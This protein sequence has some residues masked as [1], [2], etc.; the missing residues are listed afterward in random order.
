MRPFGFGLSYTTFAHDLLAVDEEVSAGD[1]FRAVV[2][3]TNTGSVP[4]D[5]VLQLYGHDVVASVTRPD[6][7]LLA[8]HRLT[9]D[10]GESADVAF[11]VPTQRF[12]FSDRSMVRIVEPGDVQVWVGADAATDVTRRAAV[13]ITGAAHALT[14]VDPRS[15]SSEVIPG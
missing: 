14:P 3:V 6:A 12:A 7:Q 9:L 5:H 1:A 2:R 15:V 13:R 11:N 4:A 10:A 8:F